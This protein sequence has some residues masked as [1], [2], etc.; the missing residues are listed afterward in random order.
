M[1]TNSSAPSWPSVLQI[2]AP[3]QKKFMRI[4]APAVLAVAAAAVAWVQNKGAAAADDIM[5]RAAAKPP[6]VD[7]EAVLQVP[8]VDYRKEWVQLGAFSILADNSADGAK[9]LHI[10]YTARQNVEA[11]LRTGRFPDGAVLVKDVFTARTEALPTGTSSYAGD[12]AGRFVMVKN[13]AG[14]LGT[15]P[16]FGDG[17]GWAFYEGAEMTR[18]VTADYKNDCL[19]CHEPARGQDLVYLQGYPLLR[20]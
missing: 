11:Y 17:W 13:D 6:A 19:P 10:V 4:F 9:Q 20:K 16:R 15:G 2:A 18:T 7:A 12:L 3:G 8:A 1:S 14:R 5:Q